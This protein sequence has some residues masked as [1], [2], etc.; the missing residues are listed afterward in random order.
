MNLRRA[1]KSRHGAFSK[2]AS[3]PAGETFQGVS[4]IG[5]RCAPTRDTA[6]DETRYPRFLARGRAFVY[7]IACRDDTLFKIGFSREPL[8]RWLGLHSQFFRFFDLD[9]SLLIATE[10]VR[11]ARILERDLL[12]S[13]ATW[14]APSPLLVNESAGGHREWFRGVLNEVLDAALA[15]AANDGL[16]QFDPASTWLRALLGERSDRLFAWM[17]YMHEA[18]EYE[19]YNGANSDGASRYR[20]ALEN[21]LAAYASV[22]VETPEFADS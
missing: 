10:S 14:R 15:H 21:V 13:F 11:A 8:R 9:Q 2:F 18:I 6:A 1:V 7:V 17:Q 16:E 5:V 3:Q 12:R 20:Q 22:G 19:T 4:R